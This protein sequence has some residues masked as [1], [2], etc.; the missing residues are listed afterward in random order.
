M[1]TGAQ[2]LAKPRAFKMIDYIRCH[3]INSENAIQCESWH[4]VADGDMCPVHRGM[5]SAVLAAN[6]INKDEY[7]SARNVAATSLRER[8]TGLDAQAQCNL[9]DAHIAGI[10]KIIEEQKALS[11][12]ARAI[13]AE[14]IEGM[15]E[16]DRQVRRNMKIPRSE[17]KVKT[18]SPRVKGTPDEMLKAF[19]AKYPSMSLEAAK[20]MLGLD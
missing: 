17:P 3:Y 1:P 10:E 19:M 13:R 7:L 20:D 16:E 5:V 4:S 18:S 8:L 12:T 14:V 6:G 11:L 9:I 2:W 15:S